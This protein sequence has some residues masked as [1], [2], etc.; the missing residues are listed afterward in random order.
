MKTKYFLLMAAVTL[1][2]S[3]CQKK[4]DPSSYAP[5][6]NI[7]GYTSAKQIA[8]SNLVSYFAFDGG[9]IDSASNTTGVNTG[10]TFGTG[11]KKQSL[12]GALNSYVLATPSNKVAALKSFTVSE[13]FNSPAPSTGIIGLFTLANTTQFWGNI[14]IFIEN[15]STA[16][17]G[18]LRIHLN[19][20][21][22]DK[23][24]QVNGV[25][26]LFGKWVNLTVS[27][28]QTT[29]TVKVYINGSRV[30]AIASTATGPLAFTNTGKFVFG[31]V[32]FQTTP[33]QTTGT[34]KQDW[35]SFLTGQIDEVRL[36]DK[37]LTDAEVSALSILEGRGK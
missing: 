32:Q 1:G 6:L 23:E 28:D 29:S 31:T 20:G 25:Q 37:A 15:G 16:T 21:G 19:Q 8:P 36:F 35:A 33:S 11:I 26:N 10:T 27:Y 4:F 3:S 5:A 2:L 9:L 7:G 13:W 24:Y 12:Q 30:A 22:S 18:K 17:D 14:E 34:T